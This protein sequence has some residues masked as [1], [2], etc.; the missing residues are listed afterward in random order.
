MT[1]P[2]TNELTGVDADTVVQAGTI[3]GDVTVHAPVF[4]GTTS[5]VTIVQGDNHGT[6]NQTIH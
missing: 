6:I 3:A 1:D 2:T 4:E 5:G